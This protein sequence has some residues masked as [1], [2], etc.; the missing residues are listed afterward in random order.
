[1]KLAGVESPGGMAAIIGLD[2]A[3]LDKICTQASTSDELVQ[4]ANDNCP[5]QVVISGSSDA[6]VRAIKLAQEAGARKVSPLAVSIASHSPL[7]HSAQEGFNQAV[8]ASPIQP[9]EVNIIGNVHALPLTTIAEIRQDLQSQLTSRVR[10]TETIL[11]LIDQ[12]VTHFIE[13]G[14]GSVLTGLLKRIS[15]EASGFALGSPADFE[16]FFQ[17]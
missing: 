15:K 9:P 6:L 1:M 17:G 16:K 5:G 4:V 14:S 12:G 8:K 13:L 3:A 7:M 2:I 11:Y 10:W